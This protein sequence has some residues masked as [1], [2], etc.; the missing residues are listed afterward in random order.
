MPDKNIRSYLNHHLAASVA[1][2]EAI[3]HLEAAERNTPMA[4]TLSELRTEVLADRRVLEDLMARLQVSQSETE[5]ATAWL[6]EKLF[7][8]MLPLNTQRRG[9]LNLLLNLEALSLG[10]EGRRALWLALGEAS[11]YTVALKGLNYELLVQRAEDQR[12]RLEKLRLEAA[13]QA[14]R[15]QQD[16]PR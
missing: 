7:Q 9:P 13:K 3:E 11:E 8:V 10:V 6:G 1:W 15:P 4:R 16:T 2:L 5:K 12:G 14:L